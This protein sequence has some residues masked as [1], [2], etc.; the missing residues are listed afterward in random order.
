M[1][2]PPAVAGG[3]SPGVVSMEV[4]P[5]ACCGAAPPRL[6]TNHVPPAATTMTTP[7]MTAVTTPAFDSWLAGFF[8][9]AG[10]ACAAAAAP[11]FTGPRMAACTRASRTLASSV[12][13]AGPICS[14]AR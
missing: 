8:A 3:V 13:A 4:V 1:L 7:M 2:L 5:A 9:A 11:L 10:F 14:N 6:S 12:S